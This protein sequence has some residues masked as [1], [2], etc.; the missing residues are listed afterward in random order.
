MIAPNVAFAHCTY[1]CDEGRQTLKEV[2]IRFPA[3]VCRSVLYQAWSNNGRNDGERILD[4]GGFFYSP[5]QL[6]SLAN[7]PGRGR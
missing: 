4:N 5:V 7:A 3:G 2:V 1:L 6:R